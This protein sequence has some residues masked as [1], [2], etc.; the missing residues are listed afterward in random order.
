MKIF[1][2]LLLTLPLFS[3]NES[4]AQ[5]NSDPNSNRLLMMST[6]SVK[7]RNQVSLEVFEFALYQLTYAPLENLQINS[8]YIP[9][10]EFTAGVKINILDPLEELLGVSI[11]GD[12]IFLR[13]SR[14]Q[15]QNDDHV[16]LFVPTPSN[17]YTKQGPEAKKIFY[18]F[19]LTSSYGDNQTQLHVSLNG[20]NRRLMKHIKYE[21]QESYYET[22]GY[23]IFD[24]EKF[25]FPSSMHFGM[26]HQLIQSR[27]KFMLETAIVYDSFE[28]MYRFSYWI[29]GIRIWS[30][31]IAMDFS[32][33]VSRTGREK[34]EPGVQIFFL[35]YLIFSVF[36]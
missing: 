24:T 11:S 3:Q 36:Y 23:D 25:I 28:K 2:L 22:D 13:E 5:K 17:I 7:P 33:L 35:P 9:Y 21:T 30:K 8:I 15:N 6:S 12:L 26:H 27:L 29:T 14:F 16:E 18:M 10:Y 20:L 4:L 32:L 34:I 1:L 19:G 31:V